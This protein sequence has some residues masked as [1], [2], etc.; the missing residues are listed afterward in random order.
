MDHVFVYP[1]PLSDREIQDRE[2]VRQLILTETNNK[3]DKDKG[4]RS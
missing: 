4:R 2:R 3:N 1:R